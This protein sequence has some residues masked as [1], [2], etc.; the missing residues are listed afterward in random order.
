MSDEW[1]QKYLGEDW[2]LVV[3]RIARGLVL[4]WREGLKAQTSQQSTA[5]D[6][7]GH[8]L[9]V[10]KRE[11]LNLA[12]SDIPGIQF[13]PLKGSRPLPVLPT[14]VVVIPIRARGEDHGRGH[15]ECRIKPN[16]LFR[17][18][19]EPVTDPEAGQGDLFAEDEEEPSS[20]A[21]DLRDMV[22]DR[23]V[24]AWIN[25]HSGGIF[26]IG[27]GVLHVVPADSS[28]LMDLRWK[29]WLPLS[30]HVAD[31]EAPAPRLRSVSDTEAPIRFDDAPEEED[32]FGLR[33]RPQRD[34][35]PNPE[36]ATES[37]REGE[38]T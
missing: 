33:V 7:F 11:Q 15:N 22:E 21:L 17:T 28:A 23:A 32:G 13:P 1:Q 16:V 10:A 35:N 3:D 18:L 20:E 25:A 27:I 38:G 8:T 31:T 9:K 19:L 6:P 34:L 5:Q 36:P 37:E 26:E 12:M 30:V 14:N 4:A 29:H 2:E 24:I